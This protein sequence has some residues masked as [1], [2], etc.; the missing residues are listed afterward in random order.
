MF[1]LGSINLALGAISTVSS[2][3][4]S[5]AAGLSQAA[6]STQVAASQTFDTAA[7]TP[8]QSAV[9][10]YGAS[11]EGST[12]VPKFDQRTQAML[13]AFQEMHRGG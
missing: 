10:T 2:L 6:G 11:N 7:A 13:L 5:A 8:P 4:E 3:L 12:V 1:G 9:S